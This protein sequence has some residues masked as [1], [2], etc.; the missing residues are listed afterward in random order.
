MF[1]PTEDNLHTHAFSGNTGGISTNHNHTFTTASAGS[2]GSH[3]H[4]IDMRLTYIDV[5]VCS[6]D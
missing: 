3:S 5:I 4:N 1:S 6:R 2:G